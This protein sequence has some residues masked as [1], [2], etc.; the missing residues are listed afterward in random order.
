MAGDFIT[1][2][3]GYDGEQFGES[4]YYYELAITPIISMPNDE[5]ATPEQAVIFDLAEGRDHPHVRDCG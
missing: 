5:S 1:F 2:G 4:T 3:W